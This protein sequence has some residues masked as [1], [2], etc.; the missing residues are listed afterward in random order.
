MQIEYNRYRATDTEVL[1][2]TYFIHSI[3]EPCT[4]QNIIIS[5]EFS[6]HFFCAAPNTS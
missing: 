5:L 1:N 4:E 3:G 2:I 6:N